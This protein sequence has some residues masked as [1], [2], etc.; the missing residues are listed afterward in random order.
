MLKQLDNYIR[1]QTQYGKTNISEIS[2][3]KFLSEIKN[4]V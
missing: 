4:P 1:T 2:Y 3:E